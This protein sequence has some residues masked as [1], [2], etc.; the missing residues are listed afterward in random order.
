MVD[1]IQE[2]SAYEK[3][4]D[5]WW[6]KLTPDEQLQAFYSVI[7]RVY[8]G[9]VV[10]Q[11]SYRYVLYDVFGFGPDSYAVGMDCG[12]MSLHN[13]IKTGE[14]EQIIQDYYASKGRGV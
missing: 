2:V 6:S 8:Q 3:E 12:Y 14:E 5:E 7:K 4:A 10:E 9:D 11:G 13:A 1:N